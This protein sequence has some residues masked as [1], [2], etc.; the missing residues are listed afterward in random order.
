MFGKQ[1]DFQKPAGAHVWETSRIELWL[2]SIAQM[3][4]ISQS[5][6]HT[7]AMIIDVMH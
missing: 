6:G 2:L 4:A 7:T 1:A 3:S 5:M